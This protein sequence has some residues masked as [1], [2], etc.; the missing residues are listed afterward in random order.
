VAQALTVSS[1]SP[2]AYSLQILSRSS[3]V[4]ASH[5]ERGISVSTSHSRV[6]PSLLLVS[7]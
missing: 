1:I 6:L 2:C 4:I 3:S 7:G 5:F